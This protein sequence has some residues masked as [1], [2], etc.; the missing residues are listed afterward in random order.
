MDIIGVEQQGRHVEAILSR[1]YPYDVILIKRCQKSSFWL[2]C[3]CTV[4]MSYRYSH[5]HWSSNWHRVRAL[6]LHL[7]A[8]RHLFHLNLPL[9][10]SHLL[11][12]SS[13]ERVVDRLRR[14]DESLTQLAIF[15]RERI[16]SVEMLAIL[17]ALKN[18][19]M[20]KKVKFGHLNEEELVKLSE[21]MQCNT[22]VKTLLI[23]FLRSSVPRGLLRERLFETM[24]TTGGWSSIQELDLMCN[25]FDRHDDIEPLSITDAENIASFIIQS[26]NL[27][28]L[29]LVMAGDDAAPIVETLSRTNVKTLSLDCSS[30]FSAETGGRRLATAL[31]GCACITKLHFRFSFYNHQVEMESLQIFFLKSIPKMLGLKMLVLGINDHVYQ[32]GFFDIVGRCIEGHPGVIEQLVLDMEH[33]PVNLSI[34]GLEPALRRLK[35]IHFCRA[36]LTS[37]QTGEL[38]EVAADCKTLEEFGFVQP[39]SSDDFEAICQVCSRLPSLKRVHPHCDEDVREEGRFTAVLEMVKT[40]KTIEQI[41]AVGCRNAEEVAA[42]EYHCRNNMMHNRIREKGLLAAKV[43]SSAWPLILK[44]FSDMPDV[45][46]YLLL[47]QKNGA[48]IGH[49]CHGCCKRKQDLVD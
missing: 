5:C 41:P 48:M 18:N 25:C 45:L 8:H 24:A 16:V 9:P 14:N 3:D 46:Y 20:V 1:V 4:N 37:Q 17:D 27:R 30:N 44:E 13:S 33:A 22:S 38:S 2:S 34:V 42:L 26:D 47:Q 43:P 12:M 31:E 36:A 39:E 15:D 11:T 28:S 49:S 10:P 29:T 40:S 32:Q 6:L 23:L 35:V 21:V 19:T 7:I